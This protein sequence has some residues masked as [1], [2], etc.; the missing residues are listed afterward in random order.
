MIAGLAAVGLVLAA[1]GLGA[2]GFVAVPLT[3]GLAGVRVVD[4]VVAFGL[5]SP[6]VVAADEFTKKK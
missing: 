5:M 2:A 3:T 6:L 4:V 1:V